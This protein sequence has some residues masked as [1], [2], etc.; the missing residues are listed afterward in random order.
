M[1]I[2]ILASLILVMCYRITKRIIVLIYDEY[3]SKHIS[4]RQRSD[5][6]R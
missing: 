3:G 1:T 2:G 5:D 4:V 6:S